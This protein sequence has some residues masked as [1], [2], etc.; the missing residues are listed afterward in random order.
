MAE[1]EKKQYS[2]TNSYEQEDSYQKQAPVSG[3]SYMSTKMSNHNQSPD[4]PYGKFE[5]LP[6]FEL[7]PLS[8]KEF[9]LNF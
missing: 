3:Q 9:S 1:T 8:I 4:S 7:K 6:N 5:S 2:K